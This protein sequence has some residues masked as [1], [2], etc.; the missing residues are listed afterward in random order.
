[1]KKILAA[2]ALVTLCSSVSYA[3]IV[4]SKHDLSFGAAGGGPKA[5]AQTQVCIFCHT[6]HNAV[7]AVPLWNRNAGAAASTY[8][9][10][11]SSAS[12]SHAKGTSSSLDATSISLFCLNCH[13]ATVAQ[14][15]SRVNKQG[16][17]GTA[18]AAAAVWTGGDATTG[19]LNIGAG[20]DLTNDHPIGFAY[21]ETDATN[22]L[23][24]AAQALVKV[25]ANKGAAPESAAIFFG[26]QS[27]R[28]ECASCHLVH[29]NSNGSFLR[30]TNAASALC[31]SCHRK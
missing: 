4:G 22:R 9:L 17:A 20:G 1:M 12:L 28:M 14:L 5:E 24:S 31:T 15:G 26:P 8:K 29:D 18:M 16:A 2:V 7:Q 11:T 6:P 27:N 30:T 19:A 10:Y 21:P 25:K 23:E 3:T 13:D